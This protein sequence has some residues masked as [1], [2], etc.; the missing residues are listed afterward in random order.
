M[1]TWRFDNCYWRNKGPK[2]EINHNGSLCFII[3][4]EFKKANKSKKYFKQNVII[5]HVIFGR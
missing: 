4:L 5:M 3:N 2:V 1:P